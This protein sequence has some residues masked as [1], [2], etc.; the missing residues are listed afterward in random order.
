MGVFTQGLPTV[1]QSQAVLLLLPPVQT[2]FPQV[3]VSR[4]DKPMIPIDVCQST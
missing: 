4:H 2:V 1:G 3:S